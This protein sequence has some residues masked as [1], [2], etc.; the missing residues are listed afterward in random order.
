MYFDILILSRLR[1]GPAHGYEIKK[2]VGRVIGGT[3]SVNNNVL[4]PSLRRFEESGIIERLPESAPEGGRPPRTVYRLTEAGAEQ[5]RRLLEDAGPATVAD[6]AEFKTRVSMFA[7]VPALVRRQL[8]ERRR[9]LVEGEL[10]HMLEMHSLSTVSES[11]WATRVVDFELDRRTAE[12]LWLDELAAAAESE[13]AGAEANPDEAST[14]RH[15]AGR[16][17]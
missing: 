6:D 3:L 2:H 13:E 7:D 9:Q 1:R 11:P 12:L 8:I 14:R 15:L 17:R 5:L 4:Y 16:Q 10:H